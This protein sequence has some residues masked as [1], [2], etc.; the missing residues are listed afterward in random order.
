MDIASVPEPHVARA[1]MLEPEAI[2]R[3]APDALELTGGGTAGPGATVRFPYAEIGEVRPSFAPTRSD[4]FRYRCDVQLKSGLGA[5]ILST[6]Y[7]RVGD[8]ENRAATYVP[9]VRGLVAR[10]A[11][12][13]PSCRFLAG[14][15]P[16]AYWSEHVFLAAMLVLLALVLLLVGGTGLSDLV[17]VKLALLA[18]FVPLAIRYA[19]KNRPRNFLPDAIPEDLLPEG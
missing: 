18:C 11:A 12:A 1:G 9:L 8:F 14:Q 4:A 15:R 19:R 5:A 2:W 13:N 7:L 16:F 6:H 3:L 10:V 17:L